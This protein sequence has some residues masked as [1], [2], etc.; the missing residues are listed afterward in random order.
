ME[1]ARQDAWV[2][3]INNKADWRKVPQDA[4]R[5]AS[6]MDVRADGSLAMRAGFEQAYGGNDVRGMLALGEELLIADGAD[7]IRFDARTGSSLPLAAIA[8]AGRF[9]GDVL[10]NELFFC[11]EN[12]TLRYRRGVLR[13][14]G[15]PTVTAQPMPAVVASGGLQAGLYQLAMTWVDSQGEEG[16]TVLPIRI[17]A[18]PVRRCASNCRP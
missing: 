17:Q 9:V 15:V 2:T 8:S 10:N 3:G 14:W 11:T 5:N 1:R 18:P 13:R 4:L 16:G 6:N 7:L 12:Q